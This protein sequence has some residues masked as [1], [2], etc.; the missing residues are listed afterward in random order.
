MTARD[1]TSR[2]V[3][4]VPPPVEIP[5]GPPVE[6]TASELRRAQQLGRRIHRDREAAERR[7]IAN[8]RNAQGDADPCR[9]GCGPM[10]RLEAEIAKVRTTLEELGRIERRIIRA[11]GRLQ[12][13]AGDTGLRMAAEQLAGTRQALA[14]AEEDL[15]VA[16]GLYLPSGPAR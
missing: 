16:A 14:Q 7:A 2:C 8:L 5:S 15:E 4:A 10:I 6:P 12:G 9:P 11:C 13:E 3:Q 1:P